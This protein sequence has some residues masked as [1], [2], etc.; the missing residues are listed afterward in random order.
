MSMDETVGA[1]DP[2]RFTPLVEDLL[3]LAKKYGA[4]DAEAVVVQS[5]SLDV[6]VRDGVREEVESAESQ[7]LGL[8]VLIGKRQAAI[9]SSDLSKTGLERLA[10]RACA[11]AAIAPQDPWCGLADPDQL[12]HDDIDLDLFDPA[13]PDIDDLNATALATEAAALAVKGVGKSGGGNAGWGAAASCMAASNGLRMVRRKSSFGCSVMVLAEKNGAMERDWAQ[14]TA[15]WAADLR[16]PED[17]GSEAGARTVAR[18]GAHKIP[19]ASL[20]VLFEPRTARSF[21]GMFLGAI[22][23]PQVARGVSFLKDRM[24]EDIFANNVNIIEDPMRQRGMGSGMVDGEG[25][26][27]TGRALI[28]QGRLTG[29]MHT[30]ASARQMDQTPTGHASLNLGG[31]PGVG[32]SN[33][34]IAAGEKT[35]DE[36]IA[37]LAHGLIVTDAFGP[38]Y[39]SGTGDW[40]VG[41]AGFEIRNGARAGAVNEITVA[42]NLNDIFAR[43]QPASDL[44]FRGSMDCPS[45]LVDGLSVAG[46]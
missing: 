18:L 41:V 37:D 34:Y 1:P 42:G 33:V 17:V 46:Q 26:A 32:A 20:P 39:N 13:I 35:P 5:R 30:L 22:S 6:S 23:G 40:S 14:S 2:A 19:S 16:T 8:R 4:S 36:L 44:E 21:L 15:R 28:D 45:L 7:D 27:R 3:R 11:M 43:I 10:E 29:W 9:T 31:P 38:S 25:L 12:A 24:G